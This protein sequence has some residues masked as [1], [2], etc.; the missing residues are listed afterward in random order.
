MSFTSTN[1]FTS[2]IQIKN[3]SYK[4]ENLTFEKFESL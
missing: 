1:C 4:N 2:T 3:P